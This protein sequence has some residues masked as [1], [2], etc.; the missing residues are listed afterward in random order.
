MIRKIDDHYLLS[1]GVRTAKIQDPEHLLERL[2]SEAKVAQIQLVK[3]LLI[4]GPEH[5]EFAAENALRAF[6]GPRPMT[7][8]LAVEL[9][10][11]I[12]CQRQISVAIQ[13][14]GI[15]RGDSEIVL[16]ALSN[17]EDSLE[18]LARAVSSTIPGE[19]DESLL[20]ITSEKKMEALKTY[21]RIEDREVEAA[22]FPGES[23]TDVLKRLVIERSALLSLES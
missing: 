12:S 15:A 2:R 11:Y 18:S 7:K 5:I 1:V 21:Y 3:A 20:E 4:A 17:S 14:M 19:R 16:V 10:L 13:R 6:K 23:D 22:R 8:S 9:L